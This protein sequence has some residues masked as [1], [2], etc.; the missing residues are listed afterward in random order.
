MRDLYSCQ[1]D[2]HV[3]RG[4]Q[5][6]QY[7]TRQCFI[8]DNIL[9]LY[10]LI[11]LSVLIA[12]KATLLTTFHWY[13]FQISQNGE[14]CTTSKRESI[15]EANH[16]RVITRTYTLL[17]KKKKTERRSVCDSIHHEILNH[18]PSSQLYEA[19]TLYPSQCSK[20]S[21][22]FNHVLRRFHLFQTHILFNK[23]QTVLS[24]G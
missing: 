3:W 16:V 14:T 19:Q 22:I 7:C 11:V 15:R 1:T 6:S 18:A 20:N 12:F 10:S 21:C 24:S 9:R 17:L 8:S 2:D 5:Y 13:Y 4:P 23:Q